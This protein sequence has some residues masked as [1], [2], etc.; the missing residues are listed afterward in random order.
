MSQDDIVGDIRVLAPLLGCHYSPVLVELC[1]DSKQYVDGSSSSYRLWSRGNYSA[2]QNSLDRVDW[3]VEFT[4][5][6]ADECNEIL[7]GIL[8]GL[9]ND[10]C[11]CL[12]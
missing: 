12:M 11:L 10:M 8:E 6:T 3:D 1:L 2:I 9:I 4:D 7:T 5:G